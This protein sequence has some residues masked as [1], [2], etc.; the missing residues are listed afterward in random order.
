MIKKNQ[1]LIKLIAV[2][3]LTFGASAVGSVATMPAITT[4]Y[5]AL[6]RPSIAPPNWLFGPVWTL[7]F[8]L[9]AIAAWRIWRLG[10]KKAGVRRALGWYWA[11]L[12]LNVCWSL[13]FFGAHSP[14]WALY[15]IIALWLAIFAAIFHFSR[16]DKTAAWL[17]A[18]YLLWVSFASILNYAF[19]MLN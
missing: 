1:S 18:P 10:L 13:V 17:L 8:L 7:L 6:A 12:I 3:G 15:V 19:W 5:A 9:M 14:Y 2:L 16:L 4:W 11:Q